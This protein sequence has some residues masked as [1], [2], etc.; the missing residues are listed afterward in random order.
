MLIL[1]LIYAVPVSVQ[2]IADQWRC[3]NK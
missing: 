2:K 3:R 1:F